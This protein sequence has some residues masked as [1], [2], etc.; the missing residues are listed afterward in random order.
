MKDSHSNEKE[1][2][3]ILLLPGEYYPFSRNLIPFNIFTYHSQKY[4]NPNN[5]LSCK[6]CSLLTTTN[7]HIDDRVSNIGKFYFPK[8]DDV[9]I[10][11]VTQKI[12]DNYKLDINSSREGILNNMEFEGATKKEK[13]NFNIGDL[14]FC[15]V[16]RVNLYDC[17]ILSCKCEFNSKNWSS[18]ESTY[19]QLKNG[20]LYDL[21][22]YLC[23]KLIESNNYILERLKDFCDYEICIGLNGKIWIKTLNE[24]DLSLSD[25]IFTAILE[26]FKNNSSQ[27]ER[28]LNKLFNKNC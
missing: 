26:S 24:N 28:I 13:P 10:G 8:K 21:N 22:Q 15:K 14:I 1:N 2:K 20:N 25:D 17:S 9:V 23:L 5:K 7:S 4:I 12:Q 11:I 19:G 3:K 27:M 16:S 18:G 6:K